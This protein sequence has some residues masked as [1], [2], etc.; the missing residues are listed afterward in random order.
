MTHVKESQMLKSCL[1]IFSEEKSKALGDFLKLLE[2]LGI[3]GTH[4]LRFQLERINMAAAISRMMKEIEAEMY[5]ATSS[6]R[7]R[8]EHDEAYP[9]EP[10]SLPFHGLSAQLEDPEIL[11]EVLDPLNQEDRD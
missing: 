3:K 4:T 11:H 10:A 2:K 5:G 9:S 1:K 7:A 6:I 8:Q